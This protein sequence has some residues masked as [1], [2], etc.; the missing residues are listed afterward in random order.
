[1]RAQPGLEDIANLVAGSR[2]GVH[3]HDF[4]GIPENLTMAFR[5]GGLDHLLPEARPPYEGLWSAGILADTPEQ[6]ASW[7]AERWNHLNDCWFS[8]QLQDASR[9]FCNR[10]SRKRVRPASTMRRLLEYAMVNQ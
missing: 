4:T 10:T 2:L 6:A 5:Y 3:S 9:Q 7:I 8:A 1:M